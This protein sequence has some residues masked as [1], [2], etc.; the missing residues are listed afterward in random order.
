MDTSN[1]IENMAISNI[2]QDVNDAAAVAH[3][4]ARAARD[5]AEVAA[6][7]MRAFAQGESEE[8]KDA[9]AK[10]IAL[11]LQKTEETVVEIKITHNIA[12]KMLPNGN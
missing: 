12:K 11:V 4:A 2:A 9:L 6:E 1:G 5:A 3:D 7:K 8:T 10:A